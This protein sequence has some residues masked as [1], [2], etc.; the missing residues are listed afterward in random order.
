M[1]ALTAAIEGS[2][3][4]LG[5]GAISS[6]QAPEEISIVVGTSGSTGE[7]KEVAL[8]A[9]ALMHCASESNK[10]LG[11]ESGDTWSLSLPLTHIAAINVLLRAHLLKTQPIDARSAGQVSDFGA[12]VPTQLFRALNGDASLLHSLQKMRAVL[13]GGAALSE[14]LY[15]LARDFGIN[16]VRTYGM[17]ETS[18]G[19]IYEGEPLPGVSY[20]LDSQGEISISGKTLASGYLQAGELE[21]S[22]FV[23]QTFKTRDFGIT[24]NGKLKVLGR[25]DDVIVTGGENLSLDKVDEITKA[26]LKSEECAAF[27]IPDQEWGAAL[28]IATTH[29]IDRRGLIREL[30]KCIGVHAKPKRF[31]VVTEIPRTSI[32]KVD[33]RRLGAEK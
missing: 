8:S 24:E 17:S 13:V 6:S 9:D 29:E 23:N 30:E 18:G 14:N 28:C 26:F 19:C 22:D 32:G 4:A 33:R 2:G 10:H 15:Q 3:P 31:I 20:S 7:G 1:D 16:V 11:A 27:A 12:I 5:F 25:L 21:R